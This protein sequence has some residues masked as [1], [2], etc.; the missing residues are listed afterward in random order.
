MTY[1]IIDSMQLI[2]QRYVGEITL[3]N[4]VNIHRKI[5]RDTNFKTGY[6]WVIEMSGSKQLFAPKEME[7]FMIFILENPAIFQNIKLAIIIRSPKQS[8]SVDIL[9]NLIH[10]YEVK[11]TVKKFLHR[12]SA[13]KWATEKP[14]VKTTT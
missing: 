14:K 4:I 13:F 1:E 7:Y 12:E 3:S 10:E 8:L 11:F 2:Y 5:I 9:D 6:D